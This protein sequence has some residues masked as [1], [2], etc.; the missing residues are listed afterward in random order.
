LYP[1]L[2]ASRNWPV[3][4]LSSMSETARKTVYLSAE[5]GFSLPAAAYFRRAGYDVKVKTDIENL[6]AAYKGGAKGFFLWPNDRWPEVNPYTPW[7]T[8]EAA[9]QLRG[10]YYDWRSGNW[11][12]YQQ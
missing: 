1:S 6:S 10:W 4:L 7:R 3:R 11:S 12:V 8:K 9:F 5:E 2:E